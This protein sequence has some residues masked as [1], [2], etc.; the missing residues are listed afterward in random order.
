[1]GIIKT[2]QGPREKLTNGQDTTVSQF[3]R[4]PV[5]A[6]ISIK[7]YKFQQTFS[8]RLIYLFVQQIKT[9]KK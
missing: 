7:A 4:P 6:F 1:M 2:S 9:V 5:Q 3:G 8:F